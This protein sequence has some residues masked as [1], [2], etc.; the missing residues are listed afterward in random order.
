MPQD[1]YFVTVQALQDI[2]VGF[3][4]ALPSLVGSVVVFLVG[5]I[6]SSWVGWGITKVLNWIK[7]NQIFA[8]GQW[9]EALAKAGIKPD[10]SEFVGQICRWIL[11]VTF[12]L[13]SVE[14]LG[15]SQFAQFLSQVI[16]WLPNVIVAVLMMVVTVIL[17][18][19]ME[20]I[21]LASVTKAKVHSA[22]AV[23]MVVRWSIYIFSL[24]AILMQL[25]I[26][27]SLIE[28]LFTGI[29]AMMVISAGLAFGLGGRDLA[30]ETL[31]SLARKLKE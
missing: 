13:A 4:Y 19:I 18:D 3:L 2:W 28:I 6:V 25:G 30:K 5:W 8:K 29:V 24:L 1:W 21:V 16:A 26:A 22:H 20:K 27:P 10:I 9:D 14:I 11:V 15:L 31:E 23:A 17:A 12:L 7:L